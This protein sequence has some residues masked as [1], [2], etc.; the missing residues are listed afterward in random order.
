MNGEADHYRSPS[1]HDNV[2]TPL[3]P[4]QP[5]DTSPHPPSPP[6]PTAEYVPPPAPARPR[7]MYPR[8]LP[9]PPRSLPLVDVATLSLDPSL[10]GVPPPYILQAL[11]EIGEFSETPL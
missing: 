3:A 7:I 2:S 9:S 5:D 1:S 8:Y 11:R 10:R 6:S 4:L